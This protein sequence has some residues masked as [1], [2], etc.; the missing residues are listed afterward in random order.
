M[1]AEETRLEQMDP[2]STLKHLSGRKCSFHKL[3]QFSQGNSALDAPA[4]YID[5]FLYRDTCISSTQLSRPM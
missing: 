1:S 4:S 5:G 3:T 2:I